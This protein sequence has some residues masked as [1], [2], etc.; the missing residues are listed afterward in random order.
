[1]LRWLHNE[2]LD[3]LLAKRWSRIA[4]SY[5]RAFVVV[6]GVALLAFGFEMTNLTLH[7]DDVAY[8]F[9]QDTILGHY[10]G[11]FG[12]GWLN[13]YTQNAYYA[14]FLQMFEGIVLMAV[15]GLLISHYWGLKKTADIVLVSSIICV[16]PYMGNVFS[17]NVVMATFPLAYCLVAMAVILS[18]RATL[19][20]V[21]LASVLYIAAFSIYQSV[22]ANAATIFVIWVL[23]R[24]LYQYDSLGRFARETWRP[25][26]TSI[27]AVVIGGA[28]YVMI[29]NAMNID[30]DS[31]QSA[32][33]AFDLTQKF[34][35]WEGVVEVVAGTRASLLWPENY[36]PDY[37]KKLQLAILTAAGIVCLWSPAQHRTRIIAGLLLVCA[38]MA[39]RILQL[40]HPHGTYHA[41]TLTAYAV[42]VAGCVMV[43]FRANNVMVR[44]AS[45]V[46]SCVLLVGFVLQCNWI[47]TV[48]HLNTLAHYTTLTQ[49]LTRV[50]M[51][52]ASEWDGQHVV[53]SGSYKMPSEYPFKRSTGV[54]TTYMD[55][56]H[57]THL[58]RLMREDLQITDA[59][60]AQPE[61]REHIRRTE[62]WPHPD[63][64]SAFD[65]RAVVV[66]SNDDR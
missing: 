33:S 52:P 25:L 45:I 48:N 38:I 2:P 8:I 37:L 51:L 3:Q 5:K 50:K 61:T 49:I 54:A 14:P 39:P 62:A 20:A 41:N 12:L 24:L 15:Y 29:V 44:N 53:V 63:S 46:A 64:V 42:V 17:Y 18:T 35:A 6:C 26:A 43:M 60:E 47:S 58:A 10:L 34:S 22:L 19:G 66:L 36:F 1:M 9:I 28:A 30:F 65:G 57:I 13:Y 55:A 23:S 40:I 59:R 21:A 32:G 56:P 31:Y 7:H 16:F 4:T 11:R 27:M